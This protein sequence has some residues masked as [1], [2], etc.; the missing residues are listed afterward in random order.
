MGY[1]HP[2]TPLYELEEIMYFNDMIS[3]RI[4]RKKLN[5]VATIDHKVMTVELWSIGKWILSS[6]DPTEAE[7][8]PFWDGWV[9]HGKL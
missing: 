8:Q 7:R 6:L 5:V 9:F 4:F 1:F 2:F 3:E